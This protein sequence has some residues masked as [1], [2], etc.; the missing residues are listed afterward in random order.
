MCWVCRVS[1]LQPIQTRTSA[2]F[3]FVWTSPPVPVFLPLPLSPGVGVTGPIFSVPLFFQFFRIIKT[4]YL[5]DI[6]LLFDRCH[7]SWAA[8]APDKY[9]CDWKYLTYTFAKSKSPVTEK[10]TNGAFGT[11]TPARRQPL[12][13]TMILPIGNHRWNLNRNTFLRRANALQND[14]RKLTVFFIIFYTWGPV[15]WYVLT[16]IPAWISNYI[17]PK[18]WVK[19]LIHFQTSAV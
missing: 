4:L 17:H 10:S 5:H 7:R 8:G 16:L 18:V 2:L 19:L 13:G 15:C 14:M 3:C 1:G 12:S 11:P 6:T 9:E